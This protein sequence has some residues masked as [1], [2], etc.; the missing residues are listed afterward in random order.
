MYPPSVIDNDFCRR[1]RAPQKQITGLTV[2]RTEIT[3]HNLDARMIRYS[4]ASHFHKLGPPVPEFWDLRR[5]S[6]I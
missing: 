5:R 1:L 6:T 4:S 3:R 2:I